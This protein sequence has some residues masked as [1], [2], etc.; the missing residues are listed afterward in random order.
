MRDLGPVRRAGAI[1]IGGG[2]GVCKSGEALSMVVRVHDGVI[3]LLPSPKT[4]LSIRCK[5]RLQW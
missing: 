4:L 1:A 5:N 3:V 2:G